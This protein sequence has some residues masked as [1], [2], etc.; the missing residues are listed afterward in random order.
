MATYADIKRRALEVL[1]ETQI[2]KNTA[3]RIGGILA[4]LCDM[5]K[6]VDG[7]ISDVDS[8]KID[9][10]SLEEYL[11]Q[12]NYVSRSEIPTSYW[13]QTMDSNRRVKGDMTDVGSLD[14]KGKVTSKESFQV[15]EFTTESGGDFS[16]DEEGNSHLTT[17]FLS[18]RRKA[19][20]E[21]LEILKTSTVGGK[22]VIS[23]VGS[24]RIAI[25]D[26]ERVT[27]NGLEQDAYRCY[28]LAEQ[29]SEKIDNNWS[30]GDQ[31]RSES[32]NL[33]AGKYHHAGNHF[34]WRLVIGRSEEPVTINGKSYHWVDLSMLDYST[35]SDAP[36]VGDVLNQ[37][38]NRNDIERQNCLV[39]SAVDTYSPSITLY[40]GIN[41]YSFANKE[42]VEYGVVKSTGKAFFNVY[43]DAYVGDRP[44]AANNYEGAS[45]IKYDS[46][47]KKV[48]I[49]GELSVKS[50][51]DGTT[52]DKYIEGKTLSE[53]EVN[54]LINNSTIISDLQNQIDGAIET[55]FY[56]GAPSL[57]NKPAI[58]WVNADKGTGKTATQDK[59]L[60]DLY[61]DNKTGKAYR[62][63]K[64][65]SVYKWT[66]I[67]D[68]DI[69]KALS[70]AA[71]AQETA[72]GK[73]TVF[74]TQ[75]TP[76]YQTGD[77]WVNATYG[78]T[79]KN[80]VLRC[81]TAKAAGSTF[82]INDWMLASKYTDDTVANEAKKA[83]EEAQKNI[84]TTQDNL[85][86]LDGT[87]TNNR[88]DFDKFTK[89]GYLDS[90]EIAAMAQDSKRLEDAFTAAEKSYNEV[91][92]SSALLD[93]HGNDVKQKTD[94][95][96]AYKELV[97][98]KTALLTY[99]SDIVTRYNAADADGKAT[100]NA[101]VA[102][103]Y[104]N[105]QTAYDDFYN[106]LGL[107]NAYVTSKIYTNLGI[108]IGDTT[109]LKYLKDALTAVDET[110]IDGG[111]ILS[112]LIALRDT[113]GKT[114]SGINGIVNSD[115]KG[116]GLA[117]WFGGEMVD[118]DY[119]DGTKTPAVSAIRFDG[120][121]YFA[122]GAIWWGADGK[123]HADPKS[124]LIDEQN[125]GVYLTLFKP[126]WKDDA[127]TGTTLEEMSSMEP[128]KPFFKLDVSGNVNVDGG[129]VKIG[130]AY[131]VYKDKALM[132]SADK[133]G[134]TPLNVYATGGIS[135]YGKG[136]TGSAG[137]GL[138]GNIIKYA[139]AILQTTANE[140]EEV[141]SAWSIK[142]LSDRINEVSKAIPS[143]SVDVP[144]TG[145]ALTGATYDDATGKLTFTKGT[146]LT[147]SALTPYLKSE[148]AKTTYAPIS[149]THTK[150]D[151]TDMPTDLGDFTNTAGFTKNT[152][153]VTSVGLTLPTGLTLG[154]TKT[155]TSSGTFAVS[156]STGYSI[157]TTAKQKQWD[158]AYT[159]NHT[160][161]NKKVLDG[162][163][164]T[165]VSNWTSAYDWYKL[166]TT[167]EEEADGVINKWNEVVNFLANIAQT[168]TLSGIIDGINTSISN[169]VTRAKK[170][171]KT[172]ADNISTNATNIKTLQGYFDADGAANKA[173]QL[174]TER[175]LW[176]VAFD[177]TKD[178]SGGLTGV[179]TILS[180]KSG[181]YNIG[182]SSNMFN[183]V[184]THYLDTPSATA[185]FF[186]TAGTTRM[187][188]N[189]SGNFGIGTT[190]IT[191]K[192]HVKGNV[193]VDVADGGYINLGGIKLY[194]DKANGA[195][196][197][198]GNI[199]ATGGV[200]AYGSSSA[201]S[202]GGGLNADILTY[203]QA[204]AMTES[205]ESTKVASAWSIKQL[206]DRISNL[207]LK[208]DALPAI[209]VATSGTG[210]AL[211]SVSYD[212][213]TGKF[214]FSKGS[215]F[216]LSSHNHDSV[217]AKKATTL[218]GYGITDAKIA[219]GVIT[220][221]AN[222]ITPLTSH[223]SLANY[224]TKTE[225][226]TLLS[227]K[228]DTGHTHTWASITNKI[229]SSD[230]FN[231]VNAGYN[232]DIY[233]NSKPFDDTTKTA[234]IGTYHFRNGS[235]EYTGIK[236][237]KFTK[238]GGT[239]SQFLKA[240]G[241]VDSNSYL[242]TSAKAADS[243]KLDN[244]H[245][246]SFF[247]GRGSAL[248]AAYA[249]LAVYTIGAKDYK[250]PDNGIYS[251]SRNG[252]SEGL[253]AFTNT[254]GSASG[255]DIIFDYERGSRLAIRRRIDSNRLSG[256]WESLITSVNIGSQS[257]SNSDKLDGFHAS[258]LFQTFS[259]AAQGSMVTMKIGDVS[260]TLSLVRAYPN[261]STGN[262]N[263]VSLFGNG[264]GMVQLSNPFASS[265]TDYATKNATVNP[266]GKAGWH[267]FINMSY[268]EANNESSAPNIWVSQIAIEAGTTNVYVRSRKGG[269][270]SDGTAWAAPWV[271]MARISD[272]VASAT[273]LATARTINGTSFNGTG[274]ITTANWGT[275]RSI[276][277]VSSD[278]TGTAVTVSVNGSA[279]VN[280]KLPS[281]IKASL[282]G[283]ASTATKLANTRTIW[284]QSFDGS[285]N[286][287]GLLTLADG[288]HSALK[289]GTAYLSSLSGNIVMQNTTALRFST[290]DAWDYNVWAGLKYNHSA[291]TIYLGLADGTIFN[292]NTAQS[293]GTLSLPGIQKITLDGVTLEY[294]STNKALK[295]NGSLYA[296]GGITAYGEGSAAGSGGLNGSVTGYDSAVKLTTEDTTQI[297]SAYS[298]ARLKSLIDGI[299]GSALT[300]VDWSI[301]K[302]K[303]STFTPSSHSHTFA[304][305]TNKPTTLSGFGIT[306]GVN[307]VSVSGSGNA[308]TSASVSG[309]TL[310]LKKEK[311]FLESV[312]WWYSGDT[313]N[314][315]DLHR[316]ITFAYSTHSNTATAGTLVDFACSTNNAYPFQLQSSYTGD[317]LY[318]R[319]KN[320]DNGTW[321]SWKRLARAEEIP[322]IANYV[323]LNGSQTISALKTF[324]LGSFGAVSIKRT[325]D[326][327]GASIQFRGNNNIYGYIGFNGATKDKQL[328]R[329]SVDTNSQ[330]DI[331][332]SSTTSLS[333]NTV[334]INGTS[335]TFLSSHQSI[336][337][338]TIQKNGSSLG[339]YTPNSASKT[340]NIGVPTKVSELTNDKNYLTQHQSFSDLIGTLDVANADFTDGTELVTSW[341]SDNGFSYTGAVNKPYKR[342]ASA[343]W[344]YIRGK[345]DSR[346][347]Q[348]SG[349]T[350]SNGAR[351]SHGGSLYLGNSNNSGWVYAQDIAS[352][353]G[354][355]SWSIRTSGAARFGDIYIASNSD[356]S[357]NSNIISS[358]SSSRMWLQYGTSANLILCNG[359]GGVM[360]GSE[361]RYASSKLTIN[362]EDLCL[363]NK[364]HG[365]T[366]WL[367]FCRSEDGGT[368]SAYSSWMMYGGSGHFYI[369]IRDN[370][371]RA[372]ILDLL[373][374]QV[375][376]NTN[377]Y[378]TG[379]V[380]AYSSS[381]LR[382]KTNLHKAD[383]LSLIKSLGSVYE[384]DYRKTNEHSYGL[385]AQNVQKSRLSD[386]VAN[387][388]EGYLKLNYWSPKLISLALGGIVQVDD[389]VTKLKKK[390]ARLEKRIKELEKT[391]TKL[392][393]NNKDKDINN[394]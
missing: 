126:H 330:Y 20:F 286:V 102:N 389:K 62:F 296:T 176:G 145:N 204:K 49:K 333:G 311:S 139:D 310:T 278:G 379:S 293:G 341:A 237:S 100:I 86:T 356:G 220:L 77:I 97:S 147:S 194:Y 258:G 71:K 81:K 386:L 72:D 61:Y 207:D 314:A 304:S 107:A 131:L 226:G 247:R 184:Y 93:E 318:Y 238:N 28:F 112:S 292:A 189:S 33:T 372:H 297:A 264:M 366:P 317:N 23:P 66:V 383:S 377:F 84:K 48:V 217:Y 1:N 350:M 27:Y 343:M 60:G 198:D 9:Y 87:V 276:G 232:G 135:A 263:S 294:D 298:I 170:A 2:G 188:L 361:D 299:D 44:T 218:S 70:D 249:D 69:T 209:T 332:D 155:I 137:G 26:E 259:H 242:T 31:A 223:Q 24:N 177:G 323:T 305:L 362:G 30:V 337:A 211:T 117:A 326:V 162:I 185:L 85:K 79:Y 265:E 355:S 255:L 138:N 200:S 151:I 35:G 371:N 88:S 360:I 183:K 165:N 65:G 193:F 295:V 340:I 111:L 224:Y 244:F 219:N 59:H 130:G 190:A 148:T 54:N 347:L 180:A 168:D 8:G 73:M 125:I 55:W 166:M 124:F 10:K 245:E 123:F 75:P 161:S 353:N 285:K 307:A 121:G 381:D 367:H 283:N 391:N 134:N 142:M 91:K 236:A 22:L 378:A 348:L 42:Y 342:K 150:A 110:K 133:D 122:N 127:T 149:H 37:V 291:K 358:F 213:S 300:E 387:D 369:D 17:D 146:F 302:N 32:F 214:T 382:L 153:T 266:N 240:D 375:C 50:T 101:A 336:Y 51:V 21:E 18:V 157:P 267:H 329:W 53:S 393:E 388:D 212:A 103:N 254:Y 338:L 313:H 12:K 368:S 345:S 152:G 38:G 106:K 322:S 90:S 174:K 243:D 390:V 43:G 228:S 303:P 205:L 349:G 222:T 96:A 270:V 257:V 167:D 231:F 201:S 83:A 274:N 192:L 357:S 272:N 215:T 253:I 344:N 92:D 227:G 80:D 230:E 169:E 116:K 29:D 119:N 113:S 140:S 181:T 384:F 172:N 309:H 3:F 74:S 331:L 25:V 118:K 365:D 273:K 279:N 105:F 63:A 256:D 197:V 154:T 206:S 15:G 163:S 373:R 58:D 136:S 203:E 324:S 320:G 144:T 339:T 271:R 196:K 288:S 239:S 104:T 321:G 277:I 7:S 132:M 52:L 269:K 99:L 158:T 268:N 392:L 315:N 57:T 234:T 179:G 175:K 352:Q 45:Y 251:I 281:T 312:A 354:T 363:Y 246:T 6:G 195:I 36:E 82:S 5:L 68:T 191:E 335:K 16:V 225:V 34:L 241:S 41:D 233:F 187:M 156:F 328:Q 235:N 178:I 98:K 67:T 199:Y 261:V 95:V 114:M 262:M 182:S 316:G 385:I 186:N 287:S 171:E 11:S 78:T 380:T 289:M 325:D 64:D 394:D 89:D 13:G 46:D 4:D 208:G 334:K 210:N 284:G 14:A 159:N 94:L 229:V 19:T 76:P 141:A 364:N 308:V 327:N 115:A 143:I 164:A 275:A 40:H 346:Y 173:V 260:K 351:I 370:N 56:D 39:F 306:D 221:G 216:S 47:K 129:Y 376:V 120:S 319:R 160:H 109:S 301:I 248:T 374:T 282:T 108:V 202:G 359:G 250:N 128:M 252:Y 290:S 280:L